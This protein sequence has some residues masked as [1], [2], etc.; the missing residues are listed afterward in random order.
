MAHGCATVGAFLTSCVRGLH[1]HAMASI[2]VAGALSSSPRANSRRWSRAIRAIVSKS[3]AMAVTAERARELPVRP[4]HDP[5]AGRREKPGEPQIGDDDHRAE[6]QSKRVESDR[7]VG[8][9]ERQRRTAAAL[10]LSYDQLG[11]TSGSAGSGRVTPSGR[12]PQFPVRLIFFPCS[13]DLASCS[14]DLF[15][16]SIT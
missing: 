9:A 2:G 5:A 8:V 16:C 14:A 10:G 7:P 12:R 15:P 4:L 3:P 1:Q 11:T 13:A 6:P